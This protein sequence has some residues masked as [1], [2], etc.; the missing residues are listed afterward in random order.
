MPAA[1]SVRTTSS[2]QRTENAVILSAS[3]LSVEMGA[4]ADR[5]HDMS[6]Q[7]GSQHGAERIDADLAARGF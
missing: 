5:R 4:Y 1:L 3:W 7:D 6:G 2:G